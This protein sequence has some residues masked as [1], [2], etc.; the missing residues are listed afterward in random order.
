MSDKSY[1]IKENNQVMIQG[2][3]KKVMK[4]ILSVA[5]ST[6][7]AFSMFASV[8][9]GD[10]ALTSQ[11]KFDILKEEGIFTGYPDGTAGLDKEMTR[12]EFAKVLVE[13]LGLEPIQNKAS[14]NDKNYA[15][16]KWPAPYVEAVYAAGIMEGKNTTKMIF[17]FNGNITVQE[18]AKVLVTVQNLEIPSETNNNASN[19]A[20]GYVQAAINAGL[21]NSSV[22]PLANANRTQLVEVAYAIYL[23]QNKPKVASYDVQEDGKVV[24]FTL[25]NS[26]KVKVTLETPLKANV[27]TEVKFTY[28]NYEY[29]ES[30]TWVVTAATKIEGVSATNYKELTVNFDGE[31]DTATAENEDN[32]KVTGVTFESA[33]LSDDKRSVTLLVAENSANNLPQQKDA[34]LEIN[35]VKNSDGSRTFKETITFRAVDTQLPEVTEVVGLGTKA[36]KVVFS[37]PVQANTAAN[38]SNY[39]ID[40]KAISGW[41]KFT[42][43]NVA[44]ITT[45]IAVGEHTLSVQG[46][47]DFANFQVKP[48]DVQFNVAEDTT[49]PEV[50]S[51]KTKDLTKVEVEF[52]ESV[53][54]VD[55]VYH[56]SSSRT[57]DKVEIKDNVVVLEF[58]G[59][60]KLSLGENTIYLQGVKDY[61]DNSANR[62]AK[63]TP[64]LDTTRP[65]V[66]D[67]KVEVEDNATVMT[68][69]FSKD[70]NL[71][72]IQKRDNFVL[73]NSKGEVVTD[74]GFNSGKPVNA[75]AYVVK[76][77]KTYKNRVEIRSIGKLPAGTYTLEVA[78]IRDT[79]TI[80]NTMLPQTLTVEVTNSET[81]QVVRAWVDTTSSN[82]DLYIDVQFNRAVAVDGNGTALDIN[83]Y[84]YV[85]GSVYKVFPTKN[86][87]QPSLRNAETVRITLPKKDISADELKGAELRVVNVADL[88]GNYLTTAQTP[89]ADSVAIPV[90]SAKAT[91]EDKVTVEFN[92]NITSVFSSDFYFGTLRGT[93]GEPKYNDGVTKVE[94][95]LNGKFSDVT[96]L[97]LLTT[98]A[99]PQSS[100]NLGHKIAKV[101]GLQ[102]TDGIAPKAIE[103]RSVVGDVYVDIEFNEEINVY[104]TPDA[105]KVYVNGGEVKV[106]GA[107]KASANVVRVELEQPFNPTI[108]GAQVSVPNN[109]NG[110]YIV[111]LEGNAPDTVYESIK[112]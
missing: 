29:T 103:A 7:M 30:V 18:M 72:D 99:N 50:V 14:F 32:Y 110:K 96:N 66:N 91:A 13:L 95:T 24:E 69:E 90:K 1:Q 53:K 12:G 31:V 28:N 87:P 54:S 81:L 46:V 15:A 43:P 39:K 83:K 59:D 51:V 105:F 97:P 68:V 57:A 67:V 78:N 8:A 73:K 10:D 71:D 106:K 88:N 102:I 44:F 111:D 64:V 70:V 23:A 62:E 47:T 86:A 6:A 101:D 45:D 22:N 82:D 89:I 108:P 75:P 76:D 37:E 41:V 107:T 34:K 9:F 38:I 20:K 33:K 35:N 94:F 93:A 52:N 16:G 42:Y 49:A 61:S 58:N 2:G 84:S 79:A 80:G 55:K 56:T 27:A 98:V 92:G 77:A 40:G 109:K 60:K 104:F 74:K 26:E 100:D 85:T 48:V 19:W 17:D 21:I 3:E 112:Y 5:L 63:V 36:F 11:Q 4:K 65:V 25:A